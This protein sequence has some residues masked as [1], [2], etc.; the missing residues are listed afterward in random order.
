MN[1]LRSVDNVNY[2]LAG[3]G[4]METTS[5]IRK[6]NSL[7]ANQK[8]ILRYFFSLSTLHIETKK[9]KNISVSIERIAEKTGMSSRS[10][11]RNLR[12]LDPYLTCT[13]RKEKPKKNLTNIYEFRP[14][15]LGLMKFL[16]ARL[17][18]NCSY[19]KRRRWIMQMERRQRSSLYRKQHSVTTNERVVSSDSLPYSCTNKNELRRQADILAFIASHRENHPIVELMR[20]EP[21]FQ[22]LFAKRVLSIAE[23]ASKR[24]N[25]YLERDIPVTN[26]TGLFIHCINKAEE[27]RAKKYRV[28]R[29]D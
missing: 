12:I 8:K 9:W 11:Q 6:F 26:H 3:K 27:A 15:A 18:L 21:H 16:D 24:Y 25:T 10:V 22:A 17:L 4:F 19:Q 14:E 5:S 2:L 23:E 20:L 29:K 7:H 1:P 28:S 13:F